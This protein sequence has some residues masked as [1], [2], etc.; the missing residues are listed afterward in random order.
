VV[1]VSPEVSSNIFAGMTLPE[2]RSRCAELIDLP[3]EP[4]ADMRSL[5]ALGHWMMRFTPAVSLYPPSTVFLDATGL[6]RLYGGIEPFRRQVAEALARLRITAAVKVAPTPGAA[7][8]LAV[9]GKNTA[10]IVT[11]ENVLKI[12]SLLPTAALRLES[13]TVHLLAALGVQTIGALFRLD[14]DDL[15]VRFGSSILMRMDQATGGIYEPLN[16]LSYRRIIQS[17]L[18]FEAAIDSIETIQMAAEQLTKD[19]AGQLAIAGLGARELKLI[20]TQPYAS[21]IEKKIQL[22]RPSRH[23]TALIKLMS[24]A[25]ETLE[26]N[27]G[28]TGI[29]LTVSISERLGDEQAALLGENEAS[30]EK[31]LD[32]L[33][34]RLRIRLDRKVGWGELLES[35]LPEN[36]GGFRD[37]DSNVKT[38]IQARSIDLSRPISLFRQPREIRVMVLPSES[39]EGHPVM[40]SDGGAVHHLHHIRGP[41]RITGQWWNG[42]WKTRDY[43]DVLDEAGWR[44]WIFRVFQNGRWFLHGVYE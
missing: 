12:I 37:T 11:S 26:T 6:E 4:E 2:A 1:S 41:E 10:N 16:F 43:F 36:T 8:A 18:E 5:E 17:H 22:M 13:Q 38:Q 3:A 9:F 27:D 40:F 21:P 33:I 32:S 35:N 30:K 14:R 39:R 42:R 34:E 28:I 7:W 31:E 44:F 15:A 24:C 23:A 20:F 25:L 19:I 29:S